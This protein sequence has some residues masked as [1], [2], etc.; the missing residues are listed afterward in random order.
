MLS[1]AKL[2]PLLFTIIITWLATATAEPPRH[3]NGLTDVVQWDNYTLFV[4]DQRIFIYS[5][6]FHAFRLPVPDLWLDIFQ[7]LKAAGF[8]AVSIYNHWGVSNPAPGDLDFDDWRNLQILFDA[9]KSAGL[10]VIFR[11]G[12]YINAETTA[13][14]I[15]HWVTSEVAGELRTNASDYRAAWT[16]YIQRIIDFVVPNQVTNGGPVIAVQVDNEY[17][18]LPL[19]HAEYFVELEAA[20]RQGGIVVPLTYNDPGMGSNFINGT[21]AVD[22]YGL[23]EYPQQFDCAQPETW[24]PVMLNYHQYHEQVNPSEPFF[25]PEFQGGSLDGWGGAGYDGCEILTGANFEDVFYKQNWA[26]NA[27][28][29]SFYMLYGGTS[30]GLL[31]YPGVYTSYDYGAA[32]RENR[33]L[34]PKYDELK[35]QGLFLRSS[36]EFR[37]TDWIGDTS[38]GNVVINNPAAFVTLLQNP[39]SGTRFYIARQNDS[40]ST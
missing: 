22:L 32:I 14:G 40:T 9:A 35:C 6:E 33:V 29:M 20:Y 16:P 4:H 7:K 11:P 23:D 5:G 21:G 39:E 37:M 27:K 2:L 15:A 19:T 24:H 34:S 3:S 25:F 1:M 31:P 8:N 17:S 18:Q 28:L 38:T 36:P 30:W 13:G 26:S 10:F 12:P